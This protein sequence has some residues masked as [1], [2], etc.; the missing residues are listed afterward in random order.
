MR[1]PMILA[2]AALLVASALTACADTPGSDADT[3]TPEAADSPESTDSAETTDPAGTTE[4]SE[5]VPTDGADLELEPGAY[6]VDVPPGVA[7]EGTPLE[8]SAGAAWTGTDDLVYVIT[9]GS[10][11]CPWIADPAASADGEVTFAPLPDG[12]CTMDY[13]PA[14]T[15]VELPAELAEQDEVTLTIG[16]WGDVTL[17]PK[18]DGKASSVVWIGE[19]LQ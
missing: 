4:P 6:V 11:T 12:P 7:E 15:V 8:A 9:F 2:A 18:T 13:R 14:T 17:P 19:A 5:P 1:R 10:G 16:T 3:T